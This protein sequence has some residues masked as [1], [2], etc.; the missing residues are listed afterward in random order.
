[1]MSENKPNQNHTVWK[2]IG[3]N[4]PETIGGNSHSYMYTDEN[5]QTQTILIDLGSLFCDEYKTGYS[6]I[7]PDA[8]VHF[9]KNDGSEKAKLPASA[10]F[11]THGHQDHIGALP[12]MIKLGYKLPPIVGSALTLE[13]VKQTLQS[14]WVKKEEWP[15]LKVVEPQNKV[16]IGNFEIEAVAVTHSMPNALGFYIKT[17]DAKIFHSGDFKTDQTIPI[18]KP[19]D[20]ERIEELSKENINAVMVDSTSVFKD[21]KVTPEKTIQK[22]ILEI[23]NQ[24]EDRR[25]VIPIISSSMQRFASIA[26]A[27]VATNKTIVLEGA[28]L[29]NSERALRK[30]GIDLSEIAGFDR[31]QSVEVN[32]RITARKLIVKGDSVYAN[33]LPENEKI[34]VCTGTQG[35]EVAAFYKAINYNFLSKKEREEQKG[36]RENPFV[37]NKDDCVVMAQ[38]CIPGNERDYYK[39][40]EKA[41]SRIGVKVYLPETPSNKNLANIEDKSLAKLFEYAEVHASGHGGKGD[42]KVLFDALTKNCTN[43]ELVVIP[44]HGSKNH[45]E[46]NAKFAKEMG[47]KTS[48]H[49]NYE[50]LQ[51]S[52]KGVTPVELK[53]GEKGLEITPQEQPTPKKT[54]W[55][56]LKSTTND[57]LKPFYDYDSIDGDYKKICTIKKDRFGENLVNKEKTKE[58]LEACR[59]RYRKGKEIAKT[60]FTKK[61]WRDHD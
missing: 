9:D 34:V 51:I 14:Q 19:F 47:L 57:W 53:I 28:S 33:S 59:D 32:G 39:I 10:I 61:F 35:E 58:T 46:E 56:G 12:H 40:L 26:K 8:R 31:N 21:E 54:F 27:A 17:P 45:L 50:G 52:E 60:I 30:A 18:G 55:I 6:N 4:N 29:I 20:Q 48:K 41:V 44:I 42:L 25:I 43:K 11:L 3:G 38:S 24:N 22:N 36:K 49:Q 1:M 2:S 7:I 16:K 37:I 15:E 5:G 13:Y 23:I